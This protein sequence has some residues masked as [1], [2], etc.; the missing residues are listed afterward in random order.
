[1]IALALLLA[2]SPVPQ[3]LLDSADAAGLAQ[4]Q[5]QFS[6]FRAARQA[7]LSSI[8]FGARLRSSCSAESQQLRTVTARIF[9]LRGEANPRAKAQQLIEQSYSTMVDEYARFPEKEKMVRDF[10]KS[11]PKDCR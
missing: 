1:M 4:T 8:E 10:C 2:G 5:C 3:S 9:A 11:D 6:A 7:H